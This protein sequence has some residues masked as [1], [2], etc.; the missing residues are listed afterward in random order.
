VFEQII[1]LS[2]K[3]ISQFL[4]AHTASGCS[5]TAKLFESYCQDDQLAPVY[6]GHRERDSCISVLHHEV[7][8][9]TGITDQTVA[10]HRV[11]E[12]RSIT[13]CWRG[14]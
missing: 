3:M 1:D 7:P 4:I 5:V 9:V 12:R 8:G 14:G 10:G 11:D 2:L 6:L 13:H